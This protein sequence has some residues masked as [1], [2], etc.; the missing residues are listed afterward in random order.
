LIVPT[1]FYLSLLPFLPLILG[2]G[3]SYYPIPLPTINANVMRKVL[4]W[5]E[6]HRKD[7][8]PSDWDQKYIQVDKEMLFE[9]VLAANFLDIKPLQ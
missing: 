6:H 9:I 2:M 1:W 4:E 5:C 8:E 3:E 7:P